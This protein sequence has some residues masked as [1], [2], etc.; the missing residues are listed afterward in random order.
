MIDPDIIVL[1][2]GM[3]CAGEALRSRVDDQL[4]RRTW[5]VLDT[6]VQ[7]IIAETVENAGAMGAALAARAVKA[8][9]KESPGSEPLALPPPPPSDPNPSPGA[10]EVTT[11]CRLFTPHV[12]VPKHDVLMW[13]RNGITSWQAYKLNSSPRKRN[14]HNSL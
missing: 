1:G 12:Y 5:T 9:R 11:E 6:N 14:P 3:A 8:T 7:I 10:K 2:G 4:R 13:F